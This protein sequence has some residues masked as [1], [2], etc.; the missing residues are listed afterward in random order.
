MN[1]HD[2]E[3]IEPI[4]LV[5]KSVIQ[6]ANQF[7]NV[8]ILNHSENIPP[9]F[10]PSNSKQQQHQIVELKPP[11]LPY[12]PITKQT[13]ASKKP[14]PII[15]FDSLREQSRV[16]FESVREFF[17][18]STELTFRLVILFIIYI[19]IIY[20]LY[21]L[22][23]AL[24]LIDS[25]FR[26]TYRDLSHSRRTIYAIFMIFNLFVD[27]YG[28]YTLLKKNIVHI[29]LYAIVLTTFGLFLL[30]IFGLLSS[31]SVLLSLF[32]ASLCYLFTY[33]EYKQLPETGVC[34]ACVHH[35]MNHV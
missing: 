30:I 23:A 8:H 28:V 2:V 24:F 35:H 22:L 17:T 27:C 6:Q 7:K 11:P 21:R 1:D 25:S 18:L 26:S 29:F 5:A 20:N 12:R 32:I 14:R 34:Q 19:S 9:Q 15:E 31:T 3:P 33:V 13:P 10:V 16:F 4:Y